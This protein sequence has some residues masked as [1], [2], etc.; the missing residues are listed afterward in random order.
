MKMGRRHDVA[1][2]VTYRF[3]YAPSLQPGRRPI[4]IATIYLYFGDRTLGQLL[5]SDR[6][7]VA[8][9]SKIDRKAVLAC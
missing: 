7:C 2:R 3:R 1:R 9:E 4:L 5:D 8:V 6:Q